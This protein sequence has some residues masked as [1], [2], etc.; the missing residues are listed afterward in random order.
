MRPRSD[1]GATHRLRDVRVAPP[2]G[3]RGIVLLAIVVLLGAGSL[4]LLLG[5]LD[6]KALRDA[7]IRR[8]ELA[9]AEAKEA[10]IGRAASD[11]NRPGSLPCPDFVTNTQSPIRNVPGDGIA[12]ALSGDD[13]PSYVGWLPWRTLGIPE[14]GDGNGEKLWY[15]LSR[16]F[17][18]DDSAEPINTS[19]AGDLT[20]DAQTEVAAIVF[21]PGPPLSGQSARPSRNF[22]DYLDLTNSDG[23]KEY[24]SA[25]A[26]ATFNDR[27]VA[28]MSADFMARVV[29]RVDRERR[30]VPAA[31]SSALLKY[32]KNEKNEEKFPWADTDADGAENADKTSGTLP[33][34]A[35]SGSPLV[36][37][38]NNKWIP[39]ISYS[40][41]TNRKS[42]TF[43]WEGRTFACNESSCQ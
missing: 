42:A 4:Y 10:L 32:F 21:S 16:N 31:A 24:A 41:E 30:R 35:L 1:R 12:D 13:C 18:N 15:A 37:M 43:A 5:Q 40:V 38:T 23:D 39:R 25:A 22:A 27:A 6:S 17:R 26:S 2:R 19:T 36:W 34:S 7:R 11:D 20:L 29:M 8:T 14:L 3:Q 33:V 28:I 9:L